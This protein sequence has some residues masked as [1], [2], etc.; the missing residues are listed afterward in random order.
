MVALSVL[1]VGLLA[2]VASLGSGHGLEREQERRVV[3]LQE[4]RQVFARLRADPDWPTLYGR[5]RAKENAAAHD[6]P[7]PRRLADGRRTYPPSTY[8]PGYV[9][10]ERLDDLGLLIEVPPRA[11]PDAKPTGQAQLREDPDIPKFGL[12]ADL[13]LDGDIDGEGCEDA[14]VIL[15]VVVI[16]AWT[17]PT[18][19]PDELRVA[20]WI[21]GDR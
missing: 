7:A 1:A 5:L 12:P 8:F 6:G 9:A 20:T 15:P 16:I 17:G 10:D 13:D 21:G 19:R 18:G 4:V 3:L 2:H 14:Y 11:K